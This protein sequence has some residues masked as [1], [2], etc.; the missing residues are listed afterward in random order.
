[1]SA[2]SMGYTKMSWH[3]PLQRLSRKQ[4]A[5]ANVPHSRALSTVQARFYNCTEH[6]TR[7]SPGDTVRTC[8]EP[9]RMHGCAEPLLGIAPATA[10]VA[11]DT[12]SQARSSP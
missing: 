7:T 4:H 5:H 8:I 12:S 2:S 3:L 9:R 10:V 6:H 11:R 1:M